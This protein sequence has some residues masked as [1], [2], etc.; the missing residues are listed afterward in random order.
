MIKS[1]TNKS[2][3]KIIKNK[4]KKSLNDSGIK[5]SSTFANM[6][7]TFKTL[8]KVTNT[9]GEISKSKINDNKDLNKSTSLEKNKFKNV[10]SFNKMTGRDNCLLITQNNNPSFSSYNPNYNSIQIIKKSSNVLN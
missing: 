10:V 5:N 9:K 4:S 8:V 2:L 7:S 6:R 3:D 1:Q